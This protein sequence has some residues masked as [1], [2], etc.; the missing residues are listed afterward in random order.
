MIKGIRLLIWMS[1][2]LR[3]GIFFPLGA[4]ITF[5]RNKSIRIT[6][7]ILIAI[8]SFVFLIFYGMELSLYLM[9]DKEENFIDYLQTDS[10]MYLLI[11]YISGLVFLLADSFAASFQRFR[12]DK[13]K[14]RSKNF[15]K[16]SPGKNFLVWILASL[17]SF[18]LSTLQDEI[19]NQPGIPLLAKEKNLTL[20][21]L[22]SLA[23]VYSWFYKGEMVFLFRGIYAKLVWSGFRRKVFL[24]KLHTGARISHPLLQ[25]I[26][27][28]AF[29]RDNFLPGWGHIYVGDFWKGFPLLFIFLLCLFLFAT[30]FFAWESPVLGIQ[31]LSSWGLK[32]GISDKEF[33]YKASNLFYLASF[34]FLTLCTYVYSKYLLSRFFTHLHLLNTQEKKFLRYGFAGFLP[35]SLLAHLILL[36]IL[37]IIPFSIQR[38]KPESS[39][40]R[41]ANHYQPDK[42]EFYFIDPNIPDDV[43]DLNGGVITGTDTPNKEEGEKISDEKAG[44]V[45][46]KSGYIKKIKGKKVP[47]TYSN[48][49]SAKMRGPE[50]YLDY[51][52]RAPQP[53]SS[54]VAYTITADGY[55]ED[56]EIIEGS[57]YPEQDLLTLELIESLSPLM[58][59][60]TNGKSVRVTEL[61]WNGSLDPDSMPTPLQSEMVTHF[62]GRYM[63]ELD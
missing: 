31:F 18:L 40:N 59:P 7:F 1:P 30:A 13:S 29:F 21:F 47:P 62:D 56:V 54:V 8:Q 39:K 24:R 22:L 43:K 34:L 20:S 10:E 50:S 15:A 27:R 2:F 16:P 52:R 14:P 45:G 4:W 51:W 63:E 60:P 32:P 48:Y 35:L 25:R 57:A 11:L 3:L 46:P 38:K 28:S 33:F 42:L 37:F 53:Y 5:F 55:I 6:S 49:I 17:L 9:W 19:Y 44:D 23:L 61:F 41:Q 36:V 58:P 26:S 12:T